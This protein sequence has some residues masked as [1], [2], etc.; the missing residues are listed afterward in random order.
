MSGGEDS[1]A[2][3]PK[4]VSPI[5]WGMGAPGVVAEI[6]GDAYAK[7]PSIAPKI[8]HLTG[9]VIPRSWALLPEGHERRPH[10]T[11]LPLEPTEEPEALAVMVAQAQGY[12]ISPQAS[13]LALYLLASPEMRHG[14]SAR[15]TLAMLATGTIG[16]S[17]K[18]IQ[19]REIQATAM[20]LEELDGLH[21]FCQMK[22]K[23]RIF[24]VRR[25]WSSKTARPETEAWFSLNRHF[26]DLLKTGVRGGPLH[27]ND[28]MAISLINLTGMMRL[29]NKRPAL[30]RHYVRAAA[31]WNA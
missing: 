31:H 2:K 29:P 18:R 26:I 28:T 25:P 30:L 11:I 16:E 5:S 17:V 27:G 4:I 21:L 23:F 19:Q 13:K 22:T 1:Y 7:E 6:E 15:A 24:S 20:A 9:K 14:G 8:P 12:V 3:L 10:Q